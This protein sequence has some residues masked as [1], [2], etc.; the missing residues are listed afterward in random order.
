MVQTV[1]HEPGNHGK[2]RPAIDRVDDNSAPRPG[3]SRKS[4]DGSLGISHVLRRHPHRDHIKAAVTAVVF[5]ALSDTFMDDI[6][7]IYRLVGIEANQDLATPRQ[8]LGKPPVTRKYIP[9][10]P[11]VKP[12]T[13]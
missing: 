3:Q 7:L 12:C 4:R 5:D 13:S 8:H 6:V 1:R 11:H 2:G 10:G 9:T